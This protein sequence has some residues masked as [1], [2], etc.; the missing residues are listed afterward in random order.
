MLKTNCF[1]DCDLDMVDEIPIP[2]RLED[3]VGKP[4]Y[5]Y[6]LH[7]LFPKIMINSVNL[8]FRE[9]LVKLLI[10][11]PRRWQVGSKRFFNDH[12]APVSILLCLT[13]GSE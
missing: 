4:G 8:V 6:V 3:R 7:G 11:Q 2:Q 10:E 9:Y 5:Q 13:G 1:G 12:P